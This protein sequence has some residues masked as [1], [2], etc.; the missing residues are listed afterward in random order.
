MS[1]ERFKLPIQKL[2]DN[3]QRPEGIGFVAHQLG[4]K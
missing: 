4:K 1:N 3:L 2:I